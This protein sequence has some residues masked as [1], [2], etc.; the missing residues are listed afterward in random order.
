M[1]ARHFFFK[2]GFFFVNTTKLPKSLKYF[3]LFWV[4]EN[5]NFILKRKR[6]G[7]LKRKREGM[8][9]NCHLKKFKRKQP[10]K[11]KRVGLLSRFL[12]LFGRMS[13]PLGSGR[14]SFP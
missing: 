11:R 8:L 2:A 7:P 14:R 13:L 5:H 9:N 4:K 6:K 3:L 12:F 1:A 10:P